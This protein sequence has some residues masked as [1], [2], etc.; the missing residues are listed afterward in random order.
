M[1][2]KIL[3]TIAEIIIGALVGFLSYQLSGEKNTIIGLLSLIP[4]ILSAIA[5]GIIFQP[6]LIDA[7]LMKIKNRLY[8]LLS[9][10]SERRPPNNERMNHFSHSKIC[11]V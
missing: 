5:A 4:G 11:Y 1:K 3:I 7:E 10:T 9:K 6:C 2:S 8:K